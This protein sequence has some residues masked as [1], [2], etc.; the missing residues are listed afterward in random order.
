MGWKF[1]NGTSPTVFIGSHLNFMKA[2]GTM[3]EYKLLLFLEN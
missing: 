3:V 1:Q 2:L